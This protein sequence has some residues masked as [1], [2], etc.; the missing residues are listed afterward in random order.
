MPIL[1]WR[2]A[3]GARYET[4]A[5]GT[6]FVGVQRVNTGE[7]W[8]WLDEQATAA[9]QDRCPQCGSPERQAWFSE[10][11]GIAIPS[12]GY[13]YYNRGLKAWVT[14]PSHYK[15]L[16]QEQGKIPL[17]GADWNTSVVNPNARAIAERERRTAAMRERQ[18]QRAESPE[19]RRVADLMANP[20]FM[21]DMLDRAGT[22]VQG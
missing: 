1:E 8:V 22:T 14:G 18:R 13:P 17:E 10:G 19:G 6:A 11:G 3:C 9:Q 4:V 5:I 16:C 15:Q 20:R 21:Q 2:C 12:N 7:D